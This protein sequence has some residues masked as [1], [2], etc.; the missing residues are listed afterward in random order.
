MQSVR[1][2]SLSQKTSTPMPSHFD[3]W[4]RLRSLL[5]ASPVSTTVKEG[6]AVYSID[7]PHRP[8]DEADTCLT[9]ASILPSCS[10]WLF[11]SVFNAAS[12][13][14]KPSSVWSMASTLMLLPL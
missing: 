6:R 2:I 14:L 9:V 5:R 1:V 10:A 8:Q 7:L 13:M 11:V 3:K 4:Y 12:A